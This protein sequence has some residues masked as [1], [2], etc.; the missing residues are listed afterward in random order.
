MYADT[1]EHNS[2]NAINKHFLK[3]I[4]NIWKP[5]NWSIQLVQI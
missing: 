3:I 5:E 2:L 1:H 4:E